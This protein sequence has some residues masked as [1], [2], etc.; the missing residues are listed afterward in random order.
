MN[1]K[2]FV[3]TGFGWDYGGNVLS[4]GNG[5]LAKLDCNGRLILTLDAPRI[6]AG[7]YTVKLAPEE[8]HAVSGVPEVASTEP[9]MRK[10]NPSVV[11]MLFQFAGPETPKCSSP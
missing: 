11:G 2:P 5:K 6:R 10:L 8:M 9:A 7:E 3:V 4:W 1:G